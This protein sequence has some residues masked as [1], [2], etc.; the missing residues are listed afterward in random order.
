M[1]R[2]ANLGFVMT[3]WTGSVWTE[4]MLAVSMPL[5]SFT[6]GE[7]PLY[8][9]PRCHRPLASGLRA[10]VDRRTH[11]HG[12]E[13]KEGGLFGLIRNQARRV[14]GRAARKT[15]ERCGTLFADGHAVEPLDVAHAH[16][17]WNHRA[18]GVAGRTENREPQNG[19]R[20]GNKHAK[21]IKIN[22]D[23]PQQGTRR[24]NSFCARVRVHVRDR[25]TRGHAEWARRSFRRRGSRLRS[26]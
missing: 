12:R 24:L 14:D 17:S 16:D 19:Q 13:K 11:T 2:I 1:S 8:G 6:F 4:G 5:K 23:R 21:A 18:H 22:R 26:G 7:K 25:P 15:R 9:G 20:G 10:C 3:D